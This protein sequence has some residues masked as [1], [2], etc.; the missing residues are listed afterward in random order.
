MLLDICG[1]ILGGPYLYERKSI[2]HRHESKYHIL[3]NGLEYIVI[4][5][6][7][8]TNVS[9]INVG[10]MKILVNLS[11]NLVLLMIKPEND[12]DYGVLDGCNS[13]LK[14]DLVDDVNQFD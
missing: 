13:N 8:K 7:K 2:F 10:Q 12:I 1:I 11:K 5:H 14:T 9:I 3:K 4:S 6:S